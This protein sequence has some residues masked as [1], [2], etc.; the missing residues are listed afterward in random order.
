LEF[1]LKRNGLRGS[2]ETALIGVIVLVGS[3]G[4]LALIWFLVRPLALFFLAIVIAQALLPVVT[5]LEQWM[6]RPLAIGSIYGGLVAGLGGVGWLLAPQLTEQV[7][8]LVEQ[9]PQLAERAQRFFNR[10]NEESGGRIGEL[11]SGGI[12]GGS[13]AVVSVPATLAQSLLEVL[14]VLFM[15]IYWL[16]AAPRIRQFV[17]SLVPARRRGQAEDVLSDLG[18]ATGGYVRGEVI[19]AAIIGVLAT[20]GLWAIGFDYPI[21][22]GIVSFIGELFP[23]LGPVVA[24]I[25]VTALA[26]LDSPTQ[27]VIVLGFYIALQQIEGQ[28]LTPNIMRHQTDV[29]QVLVLFAIFAGGVT[30]GIL[31]ALIAIPLMAAVRVLVV[32]LAVPALRAWTGADRDDGPQVPAI[33]AG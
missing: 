5:R 27:A 23:V 12:T 3:L 14:F 30:G 17:L 15:S 31:G 2:A 7:D 20:A 32:R 25:P 18:Q 28:I 4:A 26:L 24:A 22:G 8:R 6:P 19:D 9:G 21:L 16:A 13:N 10:W 29:P 11:V 1:S 33:P